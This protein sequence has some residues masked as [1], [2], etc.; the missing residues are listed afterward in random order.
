MTVLLRPG[1]FYGEWQ[2]RQQ[3][4]VFGLSVLAASAPEH[5]VRLHTHEEAHYVLVLAGVYLSQARGAPA[6]APA[7]TLVYN[8]PGTT[9][10]DRFLGGQGRFMAVSIDPA[11]LDGAD[12]LR[13]IPAG[14]CYLQRPPCLRS[15]FGLARAMQG[16]PDAA[17][18]EAGVWELLAQTDAAPARALRQPPSWLRHAYAAV[19]DGADDAGLSIGAV[20]DAAGV[21]PVHLA[22]VFRDLLGCSPG[23]LLRWRRIERACAMLR[24]PGLGIA[25][26]ALAAGFVDQS[27]LTHAFRQRFG[28]PPGVWRRRMFEGYKTPPPAPG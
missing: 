18:L 1:Q 7:P 17:L 19:M 9:H 14:A 4:G 28:V 12:E 15:A 22:R 13:A 11:R 2:D 6:C 10:R 21:H 3:G 25:D 24:R 8:P 20:A 26:I 5:E 16:A 23:E 27:H